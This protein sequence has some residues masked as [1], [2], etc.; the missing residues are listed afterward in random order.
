M[1]KAKALVQSLRKIPVLKGLSPTHIQKVFAICEAKNLAVGEVLCLKED[2]SNQM[3]V[4]IAGE[5]G[6][7]S[8]DNSVLAALTPI[9]TVGEMGMFARQKR[10]AT[11]TAIKQSRVL[12]VDRVSFEVLLRADDDMRVRVYQNVIEILSEKIMSDNVR[13]RGYLSNRVMGEKEVRSL[14]RMLNLAVAS[15]AEKSGISSEEV[16]DD[17]GKRADELPMHILVVDDEEEIRKLLKVS[18]EEYRVT[19]ASD[20]EEALNHIRAERPDLIV[21]DIKMPNMDGLGLANQL[22]KDYP[23]IPIIALSGNVEED[24]VKGHNFVGF[25]EK[26]MRIDAFKEMI[27]AALQRDL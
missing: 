4:L 8:D 17:L 22:L 1:D 7:M 13:T 24:E 26:P 19:D 9:T 16:F 25:M 27:E 11:V 18:L 21:T 10:S 2:E 12:V 14:R 15:L 23:H 20:G 5:L 6:I 3:F